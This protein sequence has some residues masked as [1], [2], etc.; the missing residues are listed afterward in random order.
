[1]QREQAGA[2]LDSLTAAEMSTFTQL[3]DEYKAKFEFPFILAVKGSACAFCS[4]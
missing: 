4:A 3:N 1:L 2:G